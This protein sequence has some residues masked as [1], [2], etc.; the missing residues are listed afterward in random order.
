MGVHLADQT[1]VFLRACLLGAALGALYD[2][3][4]IL[5]IAIPASRGIIAAQDLLF[6]VLAAIAT[7][8][9]LLTSIDG[10]VRVFL[11]VGE[12]LGWVLYYFTLGQLVMRV[13]KTIIAAIKAVFRFLLRY[14]L[15]PIYRLIYSFITLL[16]RPIRF[17]G[18]I[19]KNS[20]R[21]VKFRLKVRR[22]VLYNHLVGYF[23]K[24]LPARKPKGENAD[25]TKS[26][27]KRS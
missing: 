3:F 25:G 9:F 16:L 12:A 2:V 7:F 8:L 21:K 4:R 22:V 6:F 27:E 11:M 10:S 17:F 14:L 19:V 18:R 15:A 13:S 5:R 23:E 1:L 24:K 26:E 20:L